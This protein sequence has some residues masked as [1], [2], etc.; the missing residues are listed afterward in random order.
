MAKKFIQKAI[1]K[2]GSLTAAAKKAGKSIDQ[3]CASSNLTPLMKR[4]C[5]FYQ[6]VLKPASKKK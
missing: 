6:N 3:F 5:N 2:P 4:K 1:K